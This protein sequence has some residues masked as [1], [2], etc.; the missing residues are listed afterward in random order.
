[1][2]ATMPYQNEIKKSQLTTYVHVSVKLGDNKQEECHIKF[3]Q[4]SLE[5]QEKAGINVCLR[6][7]INLGRGASLT[8]NSFKGQATLV[9]EPLAYFYLSYKV[10]GLDEL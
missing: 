3:V 10:Q 7:Y 6:Y 5:D 9:Q 4:F 8:Q 2:G 1:M